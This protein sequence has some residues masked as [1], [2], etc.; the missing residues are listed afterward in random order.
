MSKR[1]SES[2][3]SIRTSIVLLKSP[4]GG[5]LSASKIKALLNDQITLSTTQINDIYKKAIERGFDPNASKYLMKDEF[6]TNLQ[7]TGRPSKKTEDII[8][9]V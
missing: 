2:E 3:I 8:R 9:S 1:H 5:S 7:R 6:V 4:F